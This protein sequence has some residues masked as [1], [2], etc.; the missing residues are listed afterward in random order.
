MRVVLRW[1]NVVKPLVAAWS[2]SL[3]PDVNDSLLLADTFL[4]EFRR[5]AVRHAGAIPGMLTDKMVDPPC[6]WCQL[7]SATWVGFTVEATG[8]M[9]N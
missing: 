2:R 9:L 5:R 3:M 8:G 1:E 7:T 4:D 6:H